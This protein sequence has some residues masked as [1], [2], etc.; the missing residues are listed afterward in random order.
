[1]RQ[2]IGCP[3]ACGGVEDAVA[4]MAARDSR[5][6]LCE[7]DRAGRVRA[8]I[9]L[10]SIHAPASIAPIL[11]DAPILADSVPTYSA[12]T[13]SIQTDSVSNDSLITITYDRKNTSDAAVE[14]IA[15]A[16]PGFGLFE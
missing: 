11:T 6:F 14:D 4:R 5:I 10:D 3:A 8:V 12:V 16:I 2:L 7:D 13:D 15:G 9:A 1:M